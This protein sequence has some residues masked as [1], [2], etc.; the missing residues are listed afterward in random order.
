MSL[1][2]GTR[3][4]PYEIAATLGAG[5][6]GEV[7]KA[8]DTR[9][10]RDVAIKVL[11]AHIADNPQLKQR[12]EREAR[13][14]AALSHPHICP[15]FDVGID[16]SRDSRPSVEFLVMEY[17]EGETLAQ[18]LTRGPLPLEHAVRYA[19]E[20]ADALD[21]AHRTGIV[22]RDLKPGNVML[23]KS[24][25]KLLDFGLAK[26]HPLAAAA[27][28]T[29]A[30]TVSDPL[31]GHGTILGTLHYMAPEQLEGQEAD[32]RTDIF[33][34]GAVVYEML[35]G[36]KAFEGKSQASVMVSILEHQPTSIRA[37]QP[38]IPPSLEHVILRCLAKDRDD[39]WQS[40]SDVMRELRWAADTSAIA[41]TPR[42]GGTVRSRLLWAAAS[43]A[44]MALA[45]VGTLALRRSPA[46]EVWRM[47]VV[48]PRTDVVVSF[49]ISPDGRQVAFTAATDTSPRMLMLR[50]LDQA[51]AQTLPGTEGA[52][53]PFWSPDSRAIGFQANSR[54]KRIDLNGAM[55]LD[56]A[57]AGL[58]FGG[59]WSDD[60][61]IVFSPGPG[62]GLVR[63]PASGGEVTPVTQVSPGQGSHRWPQ[64][65][66]DG[67][68]LF[69][70]LSTQPDTTGV[71]ITSLAGSPPKRI[72]DG[73][74]AARYAPPG[75]LLVVRQGVLS[76]LRF[77]LD[78][79]EVSGNPLPVAQGVG[80]FQNVSAFSSSARSVLTYRSGNASQLRQLTWVDRSGKTLG[81]V[82]PIDDAAPANPEISPNGRRV[83]VN[84]PVQG[85]NDIFTIDVVRNVMS[86]FTF[87][88]H[89]QGAALWSPD[90]Q[91]LV[92]GANPRAQMDLFEKPATGAG[93]ERLLAGT[94][95][96]ESPLD[97]SPDGQFLLY[98]IANPKTGVDLQALPLSGE[99]TPLAV[100]QSPFDEVNGQ[101]SPNGRWVAY[102]SNEG[103]RNDIYVVPF[104][105]K[106][107]KS[108]LST[109]GGTQ[110]RWR[111]DGRE[112]F[113]VAL[114]GRMMAVSVAADATGQNVEPGTPVPLFPTRLATGA[115]IGGLALSKHQY[116]V[117]S[118]GRF[119]L[120]AIVDEG[121]PPPISVI[122]NWEQTLKNE[123]R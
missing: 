95:Q 107:A 25:V 121:T 101:F 6:M 119:L 78:S 72:L 15:V 123:R 35:T 36:K 65:L 110:P 57:A 51:T 9:L 82:G 109:N 38:V 55:P 112:L 4:G 99:R 114:D 14:L 64:I 89:V 85:N 79:G 40:A 93:E 70:A 71:Y 11:P 54:L 96:N 3:L 102:Q 56:L 103:G 68:I 74:L 58:G 26:L 91:R 13:A 48:T 18:R 76:A 83:A 16:P 42:P 120:N 22:H 30:G 117:A 62:A 28:A 10:G 113:Y 63:V 50:R 19:I 105:A 49:A 104:R 52:S 12:F 39:R 5:G 122:V 1:P 80:S 32:A 67:R 60:G 44:L 34:L 7:Y 84:R 31:T 92:F 66:P 61:T 106:G 97:W 59:A 88:T 45:I 17:L 87:E 81:S 86:R 37:R 111:P 41:D 100:A 53:F 94:D 20:I 73:N 98:S 75:W 29:M 69:L 115:N 77:D 2:P 8:T 118:D 43:L 108:Q 46:P 90:G 21:K 33:A 27:G 24:G 47:D 116:A 23:T